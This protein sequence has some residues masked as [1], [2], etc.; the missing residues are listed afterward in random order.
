MVE[1]K[2]RGRDIVDR[3]VDVFASDDNSIKPEDVKPMPGGPKLPPKPGDIPVPEPTKPPTTEPTKPAI[4]KPKSFAERMIASMVK[5]DFPV[6]VGDGYRNI[7]YVEG[8]DTDGA[9]NPNHVDGFFD[10]RTVVLVRDN[11]NIELLGAWESTTEPGWYFRKHRINTNGAAAIKPGY[12]KCWTAGWHRGKQWALVQGGGPVWVYRDDNED[13]IRQGDK[14]FHG[15]FGINQHHGYNFPR[16]KIKTAS[17]GCL[18]GRSEKGHAQFMDIV[19]DDV[20]YQANKHYVFGT[21]VFEKGQ[22]E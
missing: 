21:T 12:Q 20:R 10:A 3:V 22:V 4:I 9:K 15:N 17:A 14:L 16:D 7:I 2:K 1:K 5:Y 13:G 11:G 6:D 19:T 8:T 18:V